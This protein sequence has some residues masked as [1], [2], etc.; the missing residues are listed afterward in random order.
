MKRFSLS[1]T[2]LLLSVQLSG[3]NFAPV[4]A[5]WHFT[6]LWAFN[7]FFEQTFIKVEAVG[8]TVI[9]GQ[10]CTK[11]VLGGW[12][13]DMFDQTPTYVYEE[14]SIVYFINGV[15]G[16]SEILYDL[17]AEPGDWW[18][19]VYP[20]QMCPEGIDSVM[21]TVDST[22]YENINGFDLKVLFVTCTLLNEEMCGYAWSYSSKVVERIGDFNFLFNYYT[23]CII[24]DA[25][26]PGGLRCYEDQVIGHY[27]T[28]IADS[29]DLV[30]MVGI[31]EPGEDTNSIRI[32]PNPAFDELL[33]EDNGGKTGLLHY[34][35]YSITGKM[36]LAG[37]F[38]KVTRLNLDGFPSGIYFLHVS[39][40]G[41]EQV[42][43]R[44]I[45]KK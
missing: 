32:Y 26:Y 31:D 13:C 14:D 10:P 38:G 39:R 45:I 18:K 35:L 20:T 16:S 33:I 22:G 4:G 36:I 3:Q 1:L 30:H 17:T 5:T 40:P 8:D 15:T 21:V 43:N 27:E 25:N 37:S 29:C 23:C 2:I 24:C 41:T 7:W 6:E 12:Y 19:V 28:G 11:L 9:N 42:M 44:K 34:E